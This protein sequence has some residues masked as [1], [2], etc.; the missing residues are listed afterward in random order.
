MD[1]LIT[2]GA[3]YIGSHMVL[4]AL[5]AGE[6]VVV[7][8]NLSTGLRE[9]VDPRARFVLGDIGDAALLAQ[10]FERYR[11]DA[12]LHFAGATVVPDSV[13]QPLRYYE[14]NTMGAHCLLRA[15]LRAGVGQFVFSS[16]A[17]V[18]GEVRTGLVSEEAPTRP[19]SPYGHSKL[20][21][22]QMLQDAAHA[23]GLRYAILR[24]FNVAGAD[25]AGRVGQSTPNATHL[26]K[27]ACQT[28][29][30]LHGAFHLFGQD[31]PTP[32][33]TCVRDFIHVSD[34]A[35]IH[36]ACL[37]HLRA[38]GESLLFNCGYGRGISVRQIIDH[39]E[40]VSGRSLPLVNA[41]RREGDAASVVADPSRL[42]A[43]LG[44]VPRHADIGDI[45]RSA[46][47]WEARL[48]RLAA[49]ARAG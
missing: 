23:H 34:L 17:A 10:L 2:G 31:Y 19:L 49:Q 25:M 29:L 8:D 6:Q 47:L 13:R 36:L 27:V 14:T 33:G 37:N 28:A 32:D 21:F 48:T 20:M 43:R 40:Q 30:G 41:P 5:E 7:L 18:Y 15:A 22:E 39:V 45:V 38:E 42:T 26:I 35:D 9:A 12:V 46:Y 1:I 44:W 3:G 24:Y 4:A 11:F 16:T